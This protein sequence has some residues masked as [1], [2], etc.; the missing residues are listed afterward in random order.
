VA[1]E[2]P[3]SAEKLFSVDSRLAFS[4]YHLAK[5]IEVSL[6]AKAR[7]DSLRNLKY[8]FY[9]RLLSVKEIRKLPLELVSAEDCNVYVLDCN[10]ALSLLGEGSREC[11]YGGERAAE[12]VE[13]L[14]GKELGL[15]ERAEAFLVS[16]VEM[17]K[18]GK[19][20]VG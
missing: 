12:V 2:T 16:A 6:E 18:L 15:G 5:A 17:T 9:R 4:V 1:S 13:K 19:W 20:L 10:D 3:L 7:G 14:L 11:R 8:E